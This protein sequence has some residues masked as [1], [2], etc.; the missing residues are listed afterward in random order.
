MLIEVGQRIILTANINISDQ[1]TN[2]STWKIEYM[3][4]PVQG[5]QFPRKL[6]HVITVHNYQGFTL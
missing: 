5:K 2:G 1:R 4:M 3:Q 6:G